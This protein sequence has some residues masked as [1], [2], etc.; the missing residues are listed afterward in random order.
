[1]KHLFLIICII[2]LALFATS[3]A[4]SATFKTYSF[5]FIGKWQPSEDP[6]LIDDYG[7]QDIQN[8]RKSGKHLK[9]VSGHTNYN[10]T[11]WSTAY[12]YP[13]NGFQ[14]RKD[15]PY[16]SH[17]II[18]GATATPVRT[19]LFDNTTAIPNQGNFSGTTLYQDESGATS[20]RFSYAPAG[21]MI[22]SNGKET[23]IWGGNEHRIAKFVNEDPSGVT[24]YDFTDVLNNSS[25]A[26][27]Y[28]ATLAQSASSIDSNTVLLIHFDNSSVTDFSPSGQVSTGSSGVTAATTTYRFGTGA[29]VFTSGGSNWVTVVDDADF[30]FSNTAGPV[31]TIDCWIRTL[32]SGTTDQTIISQRSDAGTYWSIYIRNDNTIKIRKFEA[33]TMVVDITGVTGAVTPATWHHFALSQTGSNWYVYLNGSLQAYS[34]ETDRL[35]DQTEDLY[36]GRLNFISAPR[37]FNGYIDEFRISKTSRYTSASFEPYASAYT[38]GNTEFDC[39]IGSYRPLKGYKIYVKTANTSTSAMSASYWNGGWN[40]VSSL[41]DG[42]SSGGKSLAQTGTV[43]FTSTISDAKPRILYG[44][45]LYWYRVHVTGISD[46]TAIYWVTVDAPFQS[47]K[48]LWDGSY[49][50]VGAAK[51]YTGS[52]YQ[53]YT[54]EVN[55]DTTTYTAVLDALATNGYFLLGFAQKMQGFQIWMAGG[56]ENSNVVS[57]TVYYWNGVSWSPVNALRDGTSGLNKTGLMTFEKTAVGTEFET[58]ISDEVPYYYY[59]IAFSGA[60]DAEVEIYHIQ[61]ITAGQPITNYATSALFQNRAFLLNNVNAY[62]NSGIYSMYNSP[63]IWNG[64]DTGTL[65]FGDE[66][67]I[68]SAAVLY[69]VFRTTAF[70]QLIVTKQ[71]ETY[72]VFGDGPDNWEVQQIS[73]IV[74][75]VAPLSMAV[76]EVA[77]ISEDLKRQVVVWQSSNGVVMTDGATIETISGDISCYWDEHDSRYIPTNRQSESVGWYDP[78]LGVY[79]LLISSGVGQTTHNVELEYS[80]QHKEWTKLYRENGAGANPLQ[81]GFTARDFNGL[82]Y[83]YGANNSGYVYRL[84]TGKTWAGTSIA[85]YVWTKDLLL[86]GDLPFFRHTVVK[87]LRLLYENKSGAAAGETVAFS[88]YGDGVLTVD[89]VS[90]QNVPDSIPINTKAMTTRSCVLGP[91]LKHSFKLSISTSNVYDGLELV[92]MGM[93][94]DSLET[95]KEY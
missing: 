75:N 22:Y 53:D 87:Y 47:I 60:L 45:E 85:Q 72:R 68:T 1:M 10:T 95:V 16:E 62:K 28:Y 81:I 67:E 24:S 88:H 51:V 31:Y 66:Q 76:C 39:Y 92:G 11:A 69:N 17:V 77:N 3:F 49:S 32:A 56:K 26:D 35:G 74:G 40:A 14:F 38:S 46:G 52:V 8:L 30:D 48:N 71:N 94:F 27:G 4:I 84:E 18:S 91:F 64:K 65:Y 80:F 78:K 13:K 37:E 86:D 21:N 7:F 70:E 33:N 82:A 20:P 57:A 12:T 42:T 59:K 61:G 23:L 41:S 19:N 29:G 79:K 73:G 89:G 50:A 54:D 58:K 83:T 36:I 55:D 9:G 93:Y 6:L 63:D 15:L 2:G 25:S 43:S 34:T 90:N 5:P 44:L